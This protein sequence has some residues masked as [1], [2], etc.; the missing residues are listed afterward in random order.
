MKICY[1]FFSLFLIFY[2]S[3]QEITDKEAFKKCKKEFSKKI[4]LSDE[5][6]DGVLFYLDKCPKE[7]GVVEN[8]GCKWADSDSDE[9]LDKD[10]ACPSVAGSSEN[11][12]CPWSDTDADGIYDKD[13]AC[14]T[15]PGPIENNGCPIQKL[16]CTQFYEE[17]KLKFEKFREDN[18]KIENIYIKLSNKLLKYFIEKN[19]KIKVD[20]VYIKFLDYGPSC[21]Y[22]SRNYVPTCTSS[23]NTD[24]YNFL[25]TKFWNNKA[26]EMF[27]QK[28]N[29]VITIK[30]LFKEYDNSYS[31]I[32][33]EELHNYLKMNYS[34]NKSYI[35]PKGRKK[36]KPN[37][38]TIGIDIRFLNPYILEI[39]YTPHSGGLYGLT[40]K[41][42]YSKGKWNELKD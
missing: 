5:D 4:C 42:E 32:L 23:R 24:E 28:N 35:F 37:P 3:A 29:V 20:Q 39:T 16:D 18:L 30:Y 13:D 14:P 40:K 15:I 19:R 26:L 38:V 21:L 34:G 7:S 27:S 25:V 36:V 8:N 9:V 10:D 1:T 11:N 31:A 22:Y 12:G 41:L 33:S 2:T 17:E 6:G